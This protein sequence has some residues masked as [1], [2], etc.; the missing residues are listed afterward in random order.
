MFRLTEKVVRVVAFTWF[1][2]S[3]I[4]YE[5]A[6][7][8]NDAKSS[9][10]GPKTQTDNVLPAEVTTSTGIELV[11]IPAGM[12]TMGCDR[13]GCTEEAFSFDLVKP[14]YVIIP[15]PFYL[16]KYPVTQDQW[17]KVMGNNPSK[18][19]GKPDAPVDNVSWNDTQKFINRVNVLEKTNRY[20]LPT[21]AEWEY[22]ARAGSQ[23]T[24]Y[25]WGDDPSQMDNYA[26]Y[27]ENSNGATH[28]VGKKRPNRWD[29]Y[30]IMG[31]VF[32]WVQDFYDIGRKRTP[33]TII[34]PQGARI[35]VERVLRGGHLR[36]MP[37]V[38]RYA[39]SPDA[40][41]TGYP[42]NIGFRLASSV[43]EVSEQTLNYRQGLNAPP[44]VPHP[45]VSAELLPTAEQIK[46]LLEYTLVKN[47]M[48]KILNLMPLITQHLLS[49]YCGEYTDF[50][51]PIQRELVAKFL[52][53]HPVEEILNDNTIT[54]LQH[55]LRD[56]D[57]TAINQD[58]LLP[59]RV[60]DDLSYIEND[61]LEHV[62]PR[63]EMLAKS[64]TKEADF[65]ARKLLDNR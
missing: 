56:S 62:I 8:N 39:N 29:L 31:N 46:P 3:N 40:P 33:D 59:K 57:I 43:G 27:N 54:V 11:L 64:F 45:P 50:P 22:S 28:P 20:R 5:G 10:M 53:K 16:G 61:I 17:E 34:D 2:C 47:R 63:I 4:L 48:T 19:Q 44:S 1:L 23:K 49:M 52:K 30:D 14:R 65:N 35:G 51:A 24:R 38:F 55:R 7:L 21:D 32:E 18:F 9:I 26:W 12:F 36:G 15:E 37:I 42:V 58:S 6:T 13:D 60:I 25:F 41:V